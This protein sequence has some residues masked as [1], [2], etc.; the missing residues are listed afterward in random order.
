MKDKTRLL[1]LIVRS[2]HKN[3]IIKNK[4]VLDVDYR[5]ECISAYKLS[6]KQ[7]YTYK[8]IMKDAHHQNCVLVKENDFEKFDYLM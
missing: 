7:R 2:I 6:E 3:D 8:V 4:Y 5:K 1:Q